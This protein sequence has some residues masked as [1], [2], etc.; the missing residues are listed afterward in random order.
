MYR[1]LV[2]LRIWSVQW[3]P[4]RNCPHLVIGIGGHCES[5]FK[6]VVKEPVHYPELPKL[7]EPPELDKATRFQNLLDRIDQMKQSGTLRRITS[8]LPPE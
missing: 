8:V 6:L 3:N 2:R 5:C 1:A 4:L 7:P